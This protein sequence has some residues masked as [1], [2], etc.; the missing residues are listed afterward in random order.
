L[1]YYFTYLRGEI[2][3]KRPAR[4]ATADNYEISRATY[5]RAIRIFIHLELCGG[6]GGIG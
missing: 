1:L 5:C 2:F 4:G 6:G 3:A